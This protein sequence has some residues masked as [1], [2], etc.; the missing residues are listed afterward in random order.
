MIG[1]CFMSP[2]HRSEIMSFEPTLISRRQQFETMTSQF[3]LVRS[4]V[5]A[6]DGIFNVIPSTASTLLLI[7]HS[8]SRTTPHAIREQKYASLC[9]HLDQAQAIDRCLQCNATSAHA[10]PQIQS[11]QSATWHFLLASSANPTACHA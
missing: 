10:C 8:A 5:A 6:R 1:H 9:H 2:F 4:L 3:G 11:S 7:L